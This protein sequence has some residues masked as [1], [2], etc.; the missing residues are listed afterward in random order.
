MGNRGRNRLTPEEKEARRL[1]KEQLMS[2]VKRRQN[3]DTLTNDNMAEEN[4]NTGGDNTNQGAGENQNTGGENNNNQDGG[5]QNTNQ[6]TGADTNQG[7]GTNNTST[8]NT[9]ISDN[10]KHQPNTQ[11]KPFKGKRIE[12]DYATPKIDVNLETTVIPEVPINVAQNNVTNE[13]AQQILNKPLTDQANDPNVPKKPE[14]INPEWNQLSDSEQTQAAETAADMMIG[15]YDKLHHFGRMYIKVEEE[16]IMEMHED[17]RIDMNAATVDNDEDP[18]KE[19][20]ILEFWQDFNKQVDE[21]FIVSPT[22]KA[23]IRPPLVRLCKKHGLGASDGLYVAYL[24]GED[25]ATKVAMLV[26]FKKTVNKM[27][28]HFE[29]RHAKFKAEVEAEVQRQLELRAAKEK[30]NNPGNNNNNQGGGNNNTAAANN[31]D[32]GE[33]VDHTKNPAEIKTEDSTKK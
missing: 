3:K 13:S 24:A 2:G 12:R 29:K 9:D 23:N 7:A 1:E 16:E 11:W 25:L 5:E 30:K 33:K 19:V 21:R 8:D 26:G 18:D 14:P 32:T 31:T 4:N 27:N 15:A 28:E 17:G 6:N 22:F 20:S 10:A